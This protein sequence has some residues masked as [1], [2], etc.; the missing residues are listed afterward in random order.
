[1]PLQNSKVVVALVCLSSSGLNHTLVYR[2][3][4]IKTR[5]A[6]MIF[7]YGNHT[8]LFYVLPDAVVIS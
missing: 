8:L 7:S 2:L 1:M 3:N 6:Y 5:G 4:V